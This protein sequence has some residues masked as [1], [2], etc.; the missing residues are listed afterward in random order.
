MY[1]NSNE[2]LKNAK[3]NKYGIGAFN[4]HCLEMLPSMV[5]SGIIKN[6]PVILQISNGTAEYIGMKLLVN[7]MKTLV[8]DTNLP[9]VLHLD[10]T[11]D[12]EMI[13]KAID[14]GFTSVMID[15]SSL[16]LSENIELTKRVVEYAHSKNVS[17]EG[18]LGT[19]GGTEEGISVHEDDIMYTR[20]EDAQKFLKETNVDAL[21]IAIGTSHG[22]YKSKAKLNFEVLKKINE[23]SDKPLV[24][25]GGTG[26]SDVDI[27]T[28][29]TNGISKINVGTEV[30]IAWI[31]EAKIQFE[32]SKLEDSLRDIIIPCNNKVEDVLINKITLFESRVG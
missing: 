16:S 12:F 4:V 9:F 31:R 11:K 29:I 24:L 28:C 3:L 6:A 30:N 19:I 7:S 1:V 26:V 18:E 2:I 32:K 15:G 14:A 21:A 27:K 17:V 13:K 5:K 23:I 20:P 22:Q 25:H 8:E 10:H